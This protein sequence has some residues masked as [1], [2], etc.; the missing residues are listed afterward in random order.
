MNIDVL[1]LLNLI[2]C[3][4]KA[5]EGFYYAL[6]SDEEVDNIGELTTN[7]KKNIPSLK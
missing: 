2:K 4:G 5:V 1:H 6:S 3:N 7:V